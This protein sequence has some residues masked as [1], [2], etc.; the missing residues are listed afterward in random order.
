[1]K[2]LF[3]C[4]LSVLA[5]SG[6]TGLAPRADTPGPALDAYGD[7]LPPGKIARLGTTRLR[8]ACTALAWA[9]DGKT[10]ASAGN[11][12]AVR[13]WDAASGK[14]VRQINMRGNWFNTLIY[15]S[16]GKYLVAGGGDGGIHIL[17]ATT[18]RDVRTLTTTFQ[19]IMALALH[20]DDGTVVTLAVGSNTSRVSDWTT[21]KIVRQAGEAL[22]KPL[23]VR[24]ALSP[25]G[26]RYGA[27]ALPDL[28]TVWDA[29]GKELFH[30]P[31]Q[32]K[33]MDGF[34]FSPDGK[35]LAMSSAAASQIA[36]WDVDTGKELRRLEGVR[37]SGS[38]LTFSPNGKYLAGKG[39]DGEVHIWGA[40]SG[41]DLRRFELPLARLVP[42]QIGNNSLVFSPD[43]KT[44]AGAHGFAIHLWE[45]EADKELHE[46]VGHNG[47]V[48]D[49]RFSADGQ[50]VLTCSRGEAG[51]WDAATAKLLHWRARSQNGV[52]PPVAALDDKTVLFGQAG[53]ILRCDVE[54]DKADHILVAGLPAAM[55]ELT[56]SADGRTLAGYTPD[57]SIYIWDG[58]SGKEKSKLKNEQPFNP[59]LV[60]SADGGL[61][62]I[63]YPN[64]AV[65]LWDVAAAREVRQFDGGI[66][67]PQIPGAAPPGLARVRPNLG[68]TYLAFSPDG[69]T[70]VTVWGSELTFWEVATGRDR[71]RVP[72]PIS[73]PAGVTFSPDGSVV[74][75]GTQDGS[76]LLL[77]AAN[78]WELTELTGQGGAVTALAFAPDGKTLGSGSANGTVLIWDINEWS[79]RK[80]PTTELSNEK[81]SASWNALSNGDASRAYKAVLALA[82]SP[83]AAAPFLKERLSGVEGA[84]D[85]RTSQLILD[86]ND[87]QFDVRE[88]TQK[89][90]EKLGEAALPAVRQALG[91]NPP[92][93]SR[94]RLQEL[95]DRHKAATTVPEE[96]RSLRALE[97]LERSGAPEAL[98]ALREL[99]KDAPNAKV[100]R[101]AAASLDR[102]TRRN[103]AP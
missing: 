75:E 65:R 40:A 87:D 31:T 73:A 38:A 86:L 90:L 56:R 95:L 1:M 98:A 16:D 20:P 30:A 11:D 102:L 5:S 88:S 46:F 25:D 8:H 69:K 41:K 100:K 91:A 68:A 42:T 6:I 103:A 62:A 18:G 44:L 92:A 79:R 99:A 50:R 14:E 74:A 94:R 47:P 78:G 82:S 77:D 93:E 54:T 10:F 84:S 53:D 37:V 72:R 97:A 58:Q 4:L 7:P 36:L 19:P 17:D 71:M 15:N 89:E 9:P 76:V 43:G 27:W 34:S 60:L 13:I 81:L 32:F 26:R 80:M 3:A 35:T 45:V 29:D 2:S 67:A 59:F 101:E 85:K 49:I 48:E 24:Q 21:G 63:G 23:F 39:A 70:L 55:M 22:G 83:K 96:V 57:R 52:L 61:L 12:G 66:P 64:M 33:A 51:Q 28:L